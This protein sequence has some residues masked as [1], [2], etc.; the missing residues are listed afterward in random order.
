M[1]YYGNWDQD[2]ASVQVLSDFSHGLDQT[3][4]YNNANTS[5]GSGGGGGGQYV[6]SQTA[7]SDGSNL[8]FSAGPSGINNISEFDGGHNNNLGTTIDFNAYLANYLSVYQGEPIEYTKSLYQ[9]PPQ[10]Q[11]QQQ[12]HHQELHQQQHN[13]TTI[14]HYPNHVNNGPS[15][16]N[17]SLPMQPHHKTNSYL[18][19]T[20]TII[21]SPIWQTTAPATSNNDNIKQYNGLES[22]PS[23]TASLL[24]P[25]SIST[26]ASLSMPSPPTSTA[27]ALQTCDKCHKKF[28]NKRSLTKHLKDDHNERTKKHACT[29][30]PYRDDTKGGLRTHFQANHAGEKPHKC[31]KCQFATSDHN[32]FRRHKLRHDGLYPYNCPFCAYKSIQSCSYKDHLKKQHRQHADIES[33]LFSCENCGFTT[34]SRAKLNSHRASCN[35]SD[36]ENQSGTSSSDDSSTGSVPAIVEN[37]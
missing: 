14:T 10:Q 4:G 35:K 9:Q 12:Q 26:P 37:N 19:A 7:I 21:S 33:Y 18:I 24:S 29:L 5:T 31:D 27:I 32:S 22:A 23:S 25:A 20:P 13:T 30:C 8:S 36:V 11:H 3:F 2:L 28:N 17:S 34:I 1:D 6:S 15:I 16:T